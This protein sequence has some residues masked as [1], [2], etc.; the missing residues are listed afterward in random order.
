MKLLFTTIVTLAM[1]QSTAQIS[2]SYKKL[3]LTKLLNPLDYIST[4]KIFDLIEFIPLETRKECLTKPSHVILTKDD[5]FIFNRSTGIL[6]FGRDGKFKGKIGRQ[7]K[8]PGEYSPSWSFQYLDN[9]IFVFD[10]MQ[11]K[12]VKYKVNETGAQDIFLKESP[13]FMFGD[14]IGHNYFLIADMNPFKRNDSGTASELSSYDMQG[15]LI[16]RFP[17]F[18]NVE[19]KKETMLP[20]ILFRKDNVVCYKSQYCDTVFRIIGPTK[21]QAAWTLSLG[22]KRFETNGN[23][24]FKVLSN[25]ILISDINETSNFLLIDYESEGKKRAVYDKRA[26]RLFMVPYS[27]PE[28]IDHCVFLWPPTG[29]IAE[30]KV[31]G[32]FISFID[33]YILAGIN[34]TKLNIPESIMTRLQELQKEVREEDNPII[35]VMKQK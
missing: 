11:K 8:G 26:D 15:N 20:V 12:I 7:G 16:Y 4:V 29:V 1:L 3:D 19:N 25:K 35:V 34:L 5:I 31:E 28:N 27:Y 2:G 30:S 13:L 23:I 24:S 9:S 21:K 6:R 17:L 14:I 22:N 18:P 10:T 33:P 32:E